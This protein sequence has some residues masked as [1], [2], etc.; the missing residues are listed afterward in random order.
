MNLDPYRY[1]TTDYHVP[2]TRPVRR[3][4]EQ[5]KRARQDMQQFLSKKRGNR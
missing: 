1:A 4:K 2:L 3:P 5:L